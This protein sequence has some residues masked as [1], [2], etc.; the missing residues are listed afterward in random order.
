MKMSISCVYTERKTDSMESINNQMAMIE[1]SGGI[2]GVY[3]IIHGM[4]S[5]IVPSPVPYTDSGVP[6]QCRCMRP[7]KWQLKGLPCFVC[8]CVCVRVC[9]CMLCFVKLVQDV[10]EESLIKSDTSTLTNEVSQFICR[11]GPLNA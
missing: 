6:A 5:A 2:S 10:S 4:Y 1:G 8:M 7:C 11:R 3:T 9:M